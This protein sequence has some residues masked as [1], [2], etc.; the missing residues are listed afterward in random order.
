MKKRIKRKNFSMPP[1]VEPDLAGIMNKMQQQM[2]MLERKIDIL[3]SKSSP[4]PVEAK[5]FHKPFQHPGP[6][7]GHGEGRQGNSFRERIMHKAIC[8]DCKKECEVPFKPSGERP[9]YCK[10]CFSKRKAGNPPKEKFDNRPRE[11][12]P[13]QAINIYKPQGGEKKRPVEKKKSPAKRRK[14]A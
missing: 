12:G 9:V 4:R 1:Q 3:I 13:A 14:G 8:A 7:H 6:A 10:E 11:A 5:P 2:V